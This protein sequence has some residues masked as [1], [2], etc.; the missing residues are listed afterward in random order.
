MRRNHY[1][2]KPSKEFG[3]WLKQCRK[4]ASLTLED[5]AKRLGITSKK[6]G[7]YLTMIEKGQRAIPDAALLNV[8]AVYNLSQE[9]VLRRA[10][11]PQLP[12]P[13]LTAVM[14][15]SVLTK[16]DNEHFGDLGEILNDEDKVELTRYAAFLIQRKN[17]IGLKK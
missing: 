13:M 9:E 12:L 8:H 4:D 11:W 17:P 15:L 5:A 16:L 2:R 3:E 14:E 7:S 6:P 10:Y 1:G